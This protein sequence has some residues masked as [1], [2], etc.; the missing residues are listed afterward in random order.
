MPMRVQDIDGEQSEAFG[1]KTGD[2]EKQNEAS[3]FVGP[4]QAVGCV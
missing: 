1:T 2:E 3:V 4:T